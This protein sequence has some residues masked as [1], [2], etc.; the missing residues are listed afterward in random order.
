[1]KAH[2]ETQVNVCHYDQ[3][4]CECTTLHLTRVLT[5]FP[6][7]NATNQR[8]FLLASISFVSIIL[9]LMLVY[10][11]EP[12]AG[13]TTICGDPFNTT[14]CAIDVHDHHDSFVWVAK[15]TEKVS[16]TKEEL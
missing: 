3:C 15:A 6:R 11:E 14:Q 16:E 13:K 10:L 9:Y 8:Y 7:R 1:M 5:P 4:F 12:V 2:S